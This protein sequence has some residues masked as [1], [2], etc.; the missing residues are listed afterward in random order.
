[1]PGSDGSGDLLAQISFP[2]IPSTTYAQVFDDFKTNIESGPLGDLLSYSAPG[3]G[4]G[5]CPPL[6]IDLVI[7]R[8]TITTDA[9]CQIWDNIK[10]ILYAVMTWVWAAVA[11]FILLS[12]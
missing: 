9:H 6:S 3:D 11:V 12:A 8:T 1:M 10:S 7:F 5:G 4:G 2:D